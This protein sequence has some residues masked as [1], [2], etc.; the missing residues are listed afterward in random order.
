VAEEGRRHVW[1]VVA[2]VLVECYMA[3]VLPSVWRVVVG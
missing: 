2:V 3:F 1:H